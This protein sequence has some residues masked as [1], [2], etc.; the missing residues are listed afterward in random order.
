M[1][2][3]LRPWLVHEAAT[4][5]FY[6]Q[7]RKYPR[8]ASLEWVGNRYGLSE[9]ERHLL[10]RGVFSQE[11]AL[12]RFAKRCRGAR[13]RTEPLY[14]D[15]H[16]V[17]ITVESAVLGRVLLLANDGALRDLAGQS[18]RFRLTQVSEMAVDL[19]FRFLEESRPRELFFFFDAPMSHSGILAN[20]YRR[21]MKTLGIPG[22]ARAVPVP[23]R[24]FPHDRGVLASSDQAV[25]EKARWWL[26]L[27]RCALDAAGIRSVFADFSYLVL[28]RR[29]ETGPRGDWLGGIRG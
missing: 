29:R 4:D 5:F 26:D 27:A 6:F 23:E 3:A 8:T 22:D 18:A 14:V 1:M 11:T 16:N 21:R 28:N 9:V 13:W 12:G 25:I 20:Q 2:K 7:N 24:E 17:Q 10:Q 19:I 15:G